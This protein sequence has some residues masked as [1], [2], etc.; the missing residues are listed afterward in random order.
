MLEILSPVCQIEYEF[1]LQIHPD[2]IDDDGKVMLIW[3]FE[4]ADLS[5]TALHCSVKAKMPSCVSPIDSV[6][7]PLDVSQVTCNYVNSSSNGKVLSSELKTISEIQRLSLSDID[8]E[9]ACEEEGEDREEEEEEDDDDFADASGL[10]SKELFAPESTERPSTEALYTETF[11]LKGSSFHEHFQRTLKSCKE[12][13]INKET[14]LIRLGKEPVNRRDENAILVH[15][16]PGDKWE[17]LGYIPGVKVL[18]VT[19]A[20]NNNEIT[21]MSLLSVKYQYVFSIS[22]FKYFAIVTISKKERWAKNR[23][24]YKYNE[25]L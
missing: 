6:M 12:K 16:C 21:S 14:I 11:T 8:E 23:D 2:E 15:A 9:N 7:P 20:I 3:D 1:I 13:M 19:Q 25:A 24:N 22:S 17:P 18:K 10:S 5:L 4:I